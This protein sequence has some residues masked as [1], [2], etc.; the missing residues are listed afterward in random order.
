VVREVEAVTA[1]ALLGIA[2]AALAALGNALALHLLRLHWSEII[3]LRD[4]SHEHATL[5][6]EHGI[7]LDHLEPGHGA[8]A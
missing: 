1:S 7:R 6:T 8:G 2:L 4:R 5:I 3:R